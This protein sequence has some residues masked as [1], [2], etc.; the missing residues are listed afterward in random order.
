MNGHEGD[1]DRVPEPQGHAAGL[2]YDF[3][4]LTWA[5]VRARAWNPDD[6]RVLTPKTFGWGLGVNYYW[7]VHPARLVRARRR[8]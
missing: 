4:R 7:L 5:R 3:G 1:Q 8:R 6:P 2:P